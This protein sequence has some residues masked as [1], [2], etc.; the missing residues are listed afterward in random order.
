MNNKLENYIVNVLE[1]ILTMSYS[2]GNE[3]PHETI[4]DI[5][6]LMFE[7]AAHDSIGACNSDTTNEDVYMR[8]KQVRDISTNLLDLHMRLISTKIKNNNEEITLTLF[9]GLPKER[10]EIIEF[11]TYIPEGNFIIKDLQGNKLKFVV[12]EKEDLSS[13]V[14]N[15]TIR[16]NPSKKIYVPEKVYKATIALKAE[17]VPAVGYCQLVLELNRKNE[18]T[19]E[20]SLDNTIENQYYSITV[21]ENG[22][23]DILDKKSNILYKEQG[24]IEDNGDDGDSYNYSIPRKDMIISSKY[25]KAKVQRIKSQIQDELL[26]E[27]ELIVPA[28]LEERAESKV[29]VTMP[30][31]I[32]VTLNDGDNIIGFK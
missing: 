5:W 29:S 1:P 8:Y 23:F 17:D 28:S 30:V 27:Y 13:Y 3:Y 20:K 25:V 14:L 22:S 18:L 6:K 31:Q 7:N 15:Q 32:R 10:N 9:N 2:L 21:N 12:K 11:K 16:L 24:I 4:K 26:V 19:I